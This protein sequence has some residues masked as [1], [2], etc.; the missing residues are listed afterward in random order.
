MAE[1]RSATGRSGVGPAVLA[2]TGAFVVLAIVVGT[3]ASVGVDSWIAQRTR[4][5]DS[6]VG[7]EVAQA[8]N[9]A[10]GVAIAILAAAAGLALAVVRRSWFWLILLAPLATV[11][12]EVLA[13]N[14]IPR[15]MFDNTPYVQLGPFLTIATPY[16]FPSGNMARVAAL[17]FA[18]LLHPSR[19]RVADLGALPGMLALVVAAAI[20]AV[21][22]WT[23]LAI[24]DHWPSDVLGG[25][26]LGTAAAFA[27]AWLLERR[28]M[29][30]LD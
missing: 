7:N 3:G 9:Q 26:L 14:V 30:T 12:I 13:K 5:P 29:A 11:P 10:S 24:G 8:I 16:T 25:L 6:T 1:G 20:L 2:C 21:A 28:E 15:T 19:A 23:H 17:V 22:A 27:L 18:L 4:L